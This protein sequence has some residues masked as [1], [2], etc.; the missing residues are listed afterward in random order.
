VAIDPDRYCASDPSPKS[1]VGAKKRR[2]ED[3]QAGWQ[4]IPTT[5][6]H[7][8]PRRTL[9]VAIAMPKGEL[10][11]C[12]DLPRSCGNASVALV[13]RCRKNDESADFP[14]EFPAGLP[15]WIVRCRPRMLER[16]LGKQAGSLLLHQQVPTM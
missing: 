8:I 6:A 2:R 13:R 3:G 15:L 12:H 5:I 7:Q 9:S 10:W 4:L 14:A 16:D 1:S 11:K